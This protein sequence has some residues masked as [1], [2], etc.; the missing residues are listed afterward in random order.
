MHNTLRADATT[1][2][3]SAAVAPVSYDLLLAIL[4][5]DLGVV[6]DVKAEPVS[7]IIT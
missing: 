3:S 7:R 6:G 5:Q 1:R 4:A 2:G